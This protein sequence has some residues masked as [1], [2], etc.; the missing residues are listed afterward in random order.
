MVS[1]ENGAAWLPGFLDKMDKS[2]GLAKNGYWPCGQ[3]KMRPS[4]IFM[5]HVKVVAYPEDPLAEIVGQIG[6]SQCLLMGSDYPH[7]EGV[8]QPRIFAEE[9]LDGLGESDI[10]AIMYENGRSLIPA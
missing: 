6:S 2:R 10:R 5:E 3:L 4:K 7:P 9:A 1:V 8:A